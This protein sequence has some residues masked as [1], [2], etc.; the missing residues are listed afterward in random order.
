MRSGARGSTRRRDPVLRRLPRARSTVEAHSTL[1]VRQSTALVSSARRR[2]SRSFSRD[3]TSARRPHQP[4]IYGSDPTTLLGMMSDDQARPCVSAF[5]VANASSDRRSVAAVM[6]SRR[7]ANDDVPGMRR[8]CGA[9]RSSHA[10]ATC[11]GVAP[12]RTATSDNVEDW[13]GVNPPSEKTARRRFGQRPD[14]RSTHRDFDGPRC[15]GSAR[16]LSRRSGALRRP[17]QGSRCS[18][19]YVARAPASGAEWLRRRSANSA[20]VSRTWSSWCIISFLF[21]RLRPC[22]PAGWMS[23]L[24]PA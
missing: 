15:N 17:A 23:A 9:R 7:C 2:E 1:C 6:F 20:V 10:S 18:A 11:I 3:V 24:L 22:C 16:T 13:R 19:R 8:M 5:N 14:G 21:I 4:T 12:R